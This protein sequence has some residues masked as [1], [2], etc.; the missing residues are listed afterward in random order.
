[1]QTKPIGHRSGATLLVRISL[2]YN[3]GTF[4]VSKVDAAANRAN[5]GSCAPFCLCLLVICLCWLKSSSF[6]LA[7][8]RLQPG[9]KTTDAAGG[10]RHAGICRTVIKVDGVSIC[11]DGLSARKHNSLH[12]S[13]QLIRGFRAEH[14]GV[15]PLQ[16]YIRMFQ[17]EERQTQAINAAR[18]RLPHSVIDHQPSLGCFYRRRTYSN[19]VRIP[20]SASSCRENDFVAS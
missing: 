8:I 15:S 4:S 6:S 5:S 1:M 16:A 2:N 11:A 7:R 19:L 9:E 13:A 17:I 3:A 18:C 20:A 10:H 14:A 12:V